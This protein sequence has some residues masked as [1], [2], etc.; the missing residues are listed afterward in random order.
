MP[1]KN[2]F[3]PS[4]SDEL[5]A[6]LEWLRE[7]KRDADIDLQA[8]YGLIECAAVSSYYRH[9]GPSNKPRH[10]PSTYRAMLRASP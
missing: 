10:L 2:G 3:E 4:T 6:E 1:D 7:Q 5:R 9:I 8:V